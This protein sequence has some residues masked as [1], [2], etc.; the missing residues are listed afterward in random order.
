MF[1]GDRI[2]RDFLALAWGYNE[3]YVGEGIA[4]VSIEIVFVTFLAKDF[5]HYFVGGFQI[6]DELMCGHFVCASVCKLFVGAKEISAAGYLCIH[7]S[8]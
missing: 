2:I 7:I 1:I 4:T 5:V 8:F 6:L 3:D